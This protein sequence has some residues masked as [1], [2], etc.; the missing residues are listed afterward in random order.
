MA[1]WNDAF[2]LIADATD[3]ASIQ[4][5]QFDGPGGWDKAT[6]ADRSYDP[7]SIEA[8]KRQKLAELQQKAADPALMRLNE[9]SATGR[10]LAEMGYQNLN[11]AEN[12]TASGGM[13]S[14]FT[15][16]PFTRQEQ[17]NPIV[18]KAVSDFQVGQGRSDMLQRAVEDPNGENIS[19]LLPVFGSQHLGPALNAI[20]QAMPGEMAPTIEQMKYNDVKGLDPKNREAFSNIDFVTSGSTPEEAM[21]RAAELSNVTGAS[22]DFVS[23]EILA[24]ALKQFETVKPDANATDQQ[25]TARSLKG[26]K[27]AQAI[28][29]SMDARKLKVAKAGRAVIAESQ[30]SIAGAKMKMD[31]NSLAPEQRNALTLAI[32]ER[33]LDPYK[34]N[35]KNQQI[36]ADAAVANPGIDLNGIAAELGVARNKD[37]IMK[38]GVAEMIPE[39]LR[40]TVVAGQ[41]L[42][43]S[44]VQFVGKLQKWKNGQL[45]DPKMVEYMTMRNDQLLTIG[46]VMRGNGMTDM[47]QR[48]EEQAAHP[49]MS[50]KALEGWLSGQLKSI[51]PRLSLYRKLTKGNTAIPRSSYSPGDGAKKLMEGE[52]EKTIASAGTTVPKRG[53]GVYTS[54]GKGGWR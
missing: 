49:T 3:P 10:P 46:G 25:L 21:K 51:D 45:N 22:P 44:D 14:S 33:R 54:D 11:R 40:E 12:N 4:G 29:D 16:D 13:P 24:P 5:M 50:P 6:G 31:M 20:R 52:S 15:T 39:L 9:F 47:A 42:K 28:L 19:N 41:K 53:G 27:E 43:Y 7:I 26:D 34:I 23:K 17:S 48:L 30:K 2:K 35:S 38:S 32:G 37:V 8:F 1:A 18:Q 36:L